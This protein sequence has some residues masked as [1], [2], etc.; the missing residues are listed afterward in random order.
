MRS[1]VFLLDFRL[2]PGPVVGSLAEGRGTLNMNIIK[3]IQDKALF[4]QL[5]K[6]LSTWRAW[7]AVLKAIF[8]LPMDDEERS[9][10]Q[11][12]TGREKPPQ[13]PFKEIY[14]IVGRR[15]G[16][17]FI[18]AVIGCFLAIFKDYT[19]FLT[20]GERGTIMILA[21][22]RKQA[23]IIFRYIKAIVSLPLFGSHVERE[24]AEAIELTN[25]INIEVHTCSYRAVRGYTIVAAIL[26]ESAFWRA[27]GANPDREI[28]IG[29]K[30]AMVT[31]PES[32]LISIS[33]P[34][35]RQGLL[36]ENWKEYFGKEDDEVLVWQAPSL[37]MN[38][39]LS[40]K[41]IEREKA[42]DLSASRAEWDAIFREDI[43]NFLPLEV[44]EK[45]IV[46]DRIELPFID[47][48]SYLGFADPAGGGG[49]SF[50]LSIGHK[51][52][53]KVIQDLLKARKGDPYEIVKE[54][55]ELLKK[56]KIH[57]VTGDKY[58]GAWV[59][60]AFRNEGITYKTS[61]LNKSELY[62]EAL[63][64]VNSGSVELLDNREL[65]KELRLLE[66]KRGSSGKDIV[67]HP[68]SIGGGVPKDDLANVTA[69][70]ITM[71]NQQKAMPGFFFVGGNRAP[72]LQE[73]YSK[74]SEN[75][76]KPNKFTNKFDR[77]D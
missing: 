39:T 46:T 31:I 29:L 61:E 35:S 75:F 7:I 42:K 56:Y 26:E 32:I 1:M 18:S 4:G 2:D 14:L 34:Y 38:P 55:A 50:A 37:T 74:W 69:G 76:D 8:A 44:I 27:E 49:D 40:E 67:D 62:L 17:S 45:V 47:N 66:R 3:A 68:K 11:R 52:N 24:T 48:F 41:T 64:Y 13:K 73:K 70:M 6:D 19:E 12:C 15:G 57:E 51:E 33:T 5:F 16:K 71:A 30:P 59:S 72:D 20:A 60:E 54:Y 63:P 65:V 43:E 10:Y 36:Y 9:L 22:D 53:G 23:G 58:A 77:G 21:V 25:R 28:Y